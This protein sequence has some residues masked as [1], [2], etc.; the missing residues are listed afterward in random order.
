VASDDSLTGLT[1]LTACVDSE[2]YAVTYYG[3]YKTS[4]NGNT[5]TKNIDA[6][7]NGWYDYYWSSISISSSGQ[8]QTA[9]STGRVRG[10]GLGGGIYNSNDYGNTWTQNI[11]ISN[12]GWN[13]KSWLSVAVSSCGQY[14]T[15]VTGGGGTYLNGVGPLVYESIY[16][17]NDYGNTW[18]STAASVVGGN[19]ISSE[20]SN[21]CV[22]TV[23]ATNSATANTITFTP[24]TVLDASTVFKFTVETL[25]A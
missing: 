2:I 17:S 5:W 14:Q 10:D 6:S 19:T 18:K 25:N 22:G 24:G 8:Y 7:N 16:Y 21:N 12:N 15:A 20:G 23:N 13:Q 9:L 3:L 4:D 11:D 1:A